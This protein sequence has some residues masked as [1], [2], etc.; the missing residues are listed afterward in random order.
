MIISEQYI[1]KVIADIRDEQKLLLSSK[2]DVE[3][4]NKKIKLLSNIVTALLHFKSLDE[5]KEDKKE[6]GKDKKQIHC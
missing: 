2:I 4:Q 1:D 3:I 5:P 6:K